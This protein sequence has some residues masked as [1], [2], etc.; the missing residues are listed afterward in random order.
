MTLTALAVQKMINPAQIVHPI[1]PNSHPGR[2]ARVNATR[3][4]M[5]V[6]AT[7]VPAIPKDTPRVI[8]PLTFQKI[9][10]LRSARIFLTSSSRPIPAIAAMPAMT[11]SVWFENT[12]PGR[13]WL[14]R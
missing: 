12:T 4:S 14:T 6:T 5:S 13:T 3:V 8:N 11:M 1:G 2:S 7:R 9:P 10:R